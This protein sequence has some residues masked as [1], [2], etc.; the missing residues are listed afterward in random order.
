MNKAR[1]TASAL[2]LT[3]L[4]ANC[5]S[6]EP[7]GREIPEDCKYFEEVHTKYWQGYQSLPDTYQENTTNSIE[8]I[9]AD[10]EGKQPPTPTYETR[11]T[12]IESRLAKGVEWAHSTA[13]V[14][15]PLTQDE[16]LQYIMR[17]MAEAPSQDVW[18]QNFASA[19]SYCNL[20]NKPPK[21]TK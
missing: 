7:Q 11:T 12:P 21:A 10:L 9:L 16:T 1:V 2:A 3:S 4:L 6:S 8:G 13:V 18:R 17:T 20:P 5:G 15:W 14:N 19:T